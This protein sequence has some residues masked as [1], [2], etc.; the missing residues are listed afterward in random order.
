MTMD[1]GTNHQGFHTLQGRPTGLVG[2]Q[3]STILPGPQEIAAKATR[4]IRNH[5]GARSTHLSATTPPSIEDTRR[6]PRHPSYAIS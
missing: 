6:L 5:G 2:L 3:E 1:G 4:A